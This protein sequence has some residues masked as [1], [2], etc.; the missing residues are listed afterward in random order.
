VRDGG[1]VAVVVLLEQE[2]LRLRTDRDGVAHLLG[3]G[4]DRLQDLPRPADER[5]AVGV[6]DVTDE[7]RRARVA[8]V[9]PREHRERVG[10][11]DEPHVRLLDAHEPLDGGAVEVDPFGKRL[12]RLVGGDGDVLHDA[13]D[14]SELEP[15]EIDVLLLDLVEYRLFIGREAAVRFRVFV[16]HV[17]DG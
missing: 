3:L 10:V 1:R 14:V 5:L 2:E 13:E 4:E 11:G 8:V 7:P 12:L 9:A 15:Q 17:L 6:D 16:R